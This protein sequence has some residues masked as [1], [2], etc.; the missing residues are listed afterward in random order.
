MA[1]EI[2]EASACEAHDSVLEGEHLVG[3][4]RLAH[5]GVAFLLVHF[6]DVG[7]HVGLDDGDGFVCTEV[8]L[9]CLSQPFHLLLHPV[10]L[11][12]DVFELGAEVRIDD[13]VVLLGLTDVNALL[14]HRLELSELF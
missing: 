11:I 10:H 12:V 5:A 7:V 8:I 4:I 1:D 9:Y 2:F 14:E 3:L 13:V 6:E